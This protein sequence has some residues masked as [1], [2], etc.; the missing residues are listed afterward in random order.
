MVT[1]GGT[2]ALPTALVGD[3]EGF[4][5]PARDDGRPGDLVAG[6]AG[7]SFVFEA[8]AGERFAADFLDAALERDA[9][10]GVM[11]RW[12]GGALPRF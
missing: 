4:A 9:V 6:F 7:E 11:G 8:A 1:V 10:A 12:Y 3:F 2:S 5:A